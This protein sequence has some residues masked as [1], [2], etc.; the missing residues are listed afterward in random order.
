MNLNK[1]FL[2]GNNIKY[3]KGLET[4][5]NLETLDL[6]DNNISHIKGLESLLNL[7][8]LWFYGNNVDSA[9]LS[10]L[11]G[12]DSGGCAIDASKFVQYCLVNL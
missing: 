3:I 9:V 1:L 6:G 5:Q 2:S 8:D 11:G 12:L 7:K 10:Q 4:L